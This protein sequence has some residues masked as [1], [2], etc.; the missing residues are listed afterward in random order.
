[1][2]YRAW[3]SSSDFFCAPH[4]STPWLHAQ[5]FLEEKGYRLKTKGHTPARTAANANELL[6]IEDGDVFLNTIVRHHHPHLRAGLRLQHSFYQSPKTYPAFSARGEEVF[7]KSVP[8]RPAHHSQF[9][10]WSYL[11]DERRILDPRN[12]TIP[13]Q[14][15]LIF[16]PNFSLE[17]GFEAL[18]DDSRA[19]FVM[20]AF[21]PLRPDFDEAPVRSRLQS[22][23]AYLDFARQLVDVSGE[24]GLARVRLPC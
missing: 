8:I 18:A 19:F 20:K 1:M 9:R 7:I 2:V 15:I 17:A 13:V 3:D 24:P 12:H 14:A 10:V 21:E 16:T 5:P 23:D 11:A 22:V 6:Y 4:F